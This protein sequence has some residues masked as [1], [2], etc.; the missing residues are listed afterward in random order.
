LGG[1]R[2]EEID[3]IPIVTIYEQSTDCLILAPGACRIRGQS[4]E[5]WGNPVDEMVA[6]PPAQFYLRTIVKCVDPT[7]SPMLGLG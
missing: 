7:G 6:T 5:G 4:D 1:G 3:R 2:E